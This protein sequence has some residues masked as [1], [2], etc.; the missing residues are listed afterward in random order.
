MDCRW[1]TKGPAGLETGEAFA[2]SA[3]RNRAIG[4]MRKARRLGMPVA[5]LAATR[6]VSRLNGTGPAS[7]PLEY[8]SS[9]LNGQPWPRIADIA[10]IGYFL[11]VAR[12]EQYPIAKL[13]RIDEPLRAAIED[14]RYRERLPSEAEAIRRLIQTGL[15]HQPVPGDLPTP[16][17]PSTP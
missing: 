14:F 16:R 2:K 11:P 12:R 15:D 17:K 6:A 13:V 10:V 9:R 4:A 1:G 8:Q 3:A 5:G 7:N